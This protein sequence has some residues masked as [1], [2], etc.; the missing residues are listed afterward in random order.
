MKINKNILKIII[1]A[2]MCF[3][4][5]LDSILI[6]VLFTNNKTYNK[7]NINN[8]DILTLEESAKYLRITN[9]ELLHIIKH[10]PFDIPYLKIYD[11]YRFSKKALNEWLSKDTYPINK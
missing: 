6:I 1:I 9:D 2:I 10:T 8:K 3:L 11:N 4:I 5:V 7:D